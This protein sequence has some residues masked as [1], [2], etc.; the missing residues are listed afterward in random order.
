MSKVTITYPDQSDV[1]D[2]VDNVV[3]FLYQQFKLWPK[4]AKLK[5][6]GKEQKLDTLEDVVALETLKGHFE[7]FVN[8]LGSS[9]GSNFNSIRRSSNRETSA[10][11]L[12]MP[13]I[14]AAQT[15]SD[16]ETQANNR[17]LGQRNENR[18]A[19]RIPDIY[20]Q[21][22]SYP[23]KI[24]P[25]YISGG[26]VVSVYW[27]GK[28]EFNVA[29]FKIDDELISESS[30][31]GIEVY[32]PHKNPNTH[33]PDVLFGTPIAEPLSLYRPIYSQESGGSW[34]VTEASNISVAY[35]FEGEGPSLPL[36]V[37]FTRV[38]D[39]T[40]TSTDTPIDPGES[41]LSFV[42]PYAGQ[43]TEVSFELVG[44]NREDDIVYTNEEYGALIGFPR[45]FEGQ[46]IEFDP[47]VHGGIDP[48]TGQLP[49]RE[50]GAIIEQ[51]ITE[52]EIAEIEVCEDID[53]GDGTMLYTRSKLQF[54]DMLNL[55][56]IRRIP[57]LNDDLTF[58]EPIGT[59]DAASIFV[60]AAI[61]PNIGRMQLEDLDLRSIRDSVNQAI[62][63]FGDNRA[64]FFSYT[65]DDIN[66]S[67]E[68][69]A[70]IISEAVFCN[71]SRVGNVL[72][73]SFR[74]NQQIPSL[75]FNDFNK[76]PNSEDREVVFGNENDYDSV[77][78]S[79][80]D[81]VSGEEVQ[82]I[83]PEDGSGNITKDINTVG[84]RTRFQAYFHAHRE[85]QRLIH[86]S[87]SVGFS[88]TSEANLLRVDDLIVVSDSTQSISVSG[89]V[90]SIN[91]SV[92]G[93][94]PV[95]LD[96]SREYVIFIQSKSGQVLK[97]MI[98]GQLSPSLIILDSEITEE[99]LSLDRDNFA[100]ATYTI[101]E[102]SE[103]DLDLFLVTRKTIRDNLVIELEAINYS[104]EYFARDA[105]FIEGVFTDTDDSSVT[106]FGATAPIFRHIRPNNFFTYNT[107]LPSI[108]NVDFSA[109]DVNGDDIIYSIAG[110]D[111]A[112][113]E[114]DDNNRRRF[115]T[116]PVTVSPTDADGN[117][118]Y[119]VIA[120]ISDGTL[121]R[122]NPI[123]IGVA[124]SSFTFFFNDRVE[125]LP[126][127]APYFSNLTTGQVSLVQENVT[128]SFFTVQGF[129]PNGDPFSF[130]IVGGADA[131]FFSLSQSGELSFNTP[132]DF[133]TPL[134][135]N[136][137][138]V[139]HVTIRISDGSL[140]RDATL[141]VQVT[142]QDETEETP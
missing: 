137:D 76:L 110:E 17:I 2:N 59:R 103:S 72:E 85:Y 42:N 36:R 91:E 96:E 120:T 26:Y 57:F 44:F 10:V 89:E 139:Y 40:A 111:A 88:T 92:L 31:Y 136:A 51:E 29:D 25:D 37:T 68:D 138:N 67:F 121:T 9:S 35:N 34:P 73:M 133:E 132:P 19:R 56:A 80:F 116:P 77:N 46:L 11:S 64:S 142:D 28:G 45:F 126:P 16:M 90:S 125:S 100:R 94:R 39:Q 12:T 24:F 27:V 118:F 7:V 87:L 23:D 30:E 140:F 66:L 104:P 79:Y 106:T 115:R 14:F 134:D 101:T 78:L 99:E 112:L 8:P 49:V 32:G 47:N 53:F 5:F 18:T 6:N 63:T 127:I 131:Q 33:E 119:E 62:T 71:V 128:G 15:Q 135:S 93:V 74:G 95:T 84:I 86:Q 82:Y 102:D 69:I 129:D 38:S 54:N 98:T 130:L 41:A 107:N 81:Q 58:T 97:R 70:D 83:V 13:Q 65:F 124:D 52:S 1:Y 114:L 22:R 48:L 117:G 61:D 50:Q 122:T 21:V 109:Y 75:L 123:T 141:N 55:L 113:F 108:F 4:G 3:E 60:A 43:P 105:D 20:G